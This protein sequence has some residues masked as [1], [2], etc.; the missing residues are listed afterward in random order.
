MEQYN[1]RMDNYFLSIP[2][3]NQELWRNG[4]QTLYDSMKSS[5]VDPIVI[6]RQY[7]DVHDEFSDFKDYNFENITEGEFI[8]GLRK[9]YYGEFMQQFID[10]HRNFYDKINQLSQDSSNRQETATR[11]LETYKGLIDGIKEINGKSEDLASAFHENIPDEFGL[12]NIL[13]N[14]LSRHIECFAYPRSRETRT[15]DYF[16]SLG[17]YFVMKSGIDELKPSEF[18]FSPVDEPFIEEMH[19]GFLSSYKSR[20]RFV[21]ETM[22]RIDLVKLREKKMLN[23]IRKK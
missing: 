2:S 18:L 3:T 12:R 19:P 1:P 13:E 11:V 22:N 17:D 21:E 6:D 8:V 4:M 20:L 10:K 5:V 7:F 15:Q 9:V 23:L 14:R 16:T